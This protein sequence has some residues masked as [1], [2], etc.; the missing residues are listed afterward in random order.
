MAKSPKTDAFQ[1]KADFLPITVLRFFS[2][3]TDTF[4]QQ[5]DS[6]IQKA[7]NYFS[8]AP[9]IMDFSQ[10][11]ES[12]PNPDMKTLCALLRNYNMQPIAAR[13]LSHTLELPILPN[14]IEKKSPPKK[15]AKESQT[16]STKMIDKPV[17]AGTQIYA[18]DG[19]L[20]ILSSV[21]AGAEVIAD[22][23]IHIYGP[24][25]GRALAGA[26]GNTEARIFCKS[27]EAELVAIAGHYWVKDQIKTPKSK[28]AI[29][30]V[31]LQDEKLQIE[32]V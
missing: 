27:L 16:Q 20:I 3:E 15:V 22:G 1:L 2:A 12:N 19:D 24:L 26:S 7:P 8:N 10:L 18:K 25:R 30:Q 28:S 5:L 11:E 4:Q 6:L 21:N 29:I 13:G 9:V 32:T 31:F 17:R 23:N 14:H